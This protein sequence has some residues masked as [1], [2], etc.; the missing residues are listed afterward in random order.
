[1]YRTYPVNLPPVCL[2]LSTLAVKPILVTLFFSVTILRSLIVAFL[3]PPPL[4]PWLPRLYNNPVFLPIIASVY[5]LEG[6]TFCLYLLYS[7]RSSLAP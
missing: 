2:V 3:S 6:A 4:L 7:P 5:C 1:M